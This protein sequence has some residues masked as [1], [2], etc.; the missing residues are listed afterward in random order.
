MRKFE[1]YKA[2]L[3]AR[4]PTPKPPLGEESQRAL[5]DVELVA[6]PTWYYVAAAAAV[7]A[8][9]AALHLAT[10]FEVLPAR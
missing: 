9:F 6:F 1:E 4:I 5:A 3:A 10:L 8:V 2:R 7:L